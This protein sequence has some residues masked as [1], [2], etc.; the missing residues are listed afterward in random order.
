MSGLTHF[1][2]SNNDQNLVKMI[3]TRDFI[4]KPR[5]ICHKGKANYLRQC[6]EFL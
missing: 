1:F 5:I 3:P 2:I 4:C 6:K